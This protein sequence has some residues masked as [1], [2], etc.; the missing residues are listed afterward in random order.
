MKCIFISNVLNEEFINDNNVPAISYADNMAQLELLQRLK[1]VY[2]DNLIV[3]TAAYND[4]KTLKH[5]QDTT[6]AR[7]IELI[8][9]K[10]CSKNKV[11]YYLTIIKGYYKELCHYLEL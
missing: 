1:E 7:N 10:N 4:F 8:G 6:Y 3:I 9:V 2:K 11:I 5:K